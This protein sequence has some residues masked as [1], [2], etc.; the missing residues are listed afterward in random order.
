MWPSRVRASSSAAMSCGTRSV[1]APSPV[2]RFQ[3]FGHAADDAD[4]ARAPR[5]DPDLVALV[6]EHDRGFAH[7]E[8]QPPA[9]EGVLDMRLD[10]ARGPGVDAHMAVLRGDVHI[11]VRG[12]VPALVP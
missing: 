7:T 5:G 12:H 6:L 4:A 10:V 11:R 8:Q 9:L 1:T 2:S 3:P